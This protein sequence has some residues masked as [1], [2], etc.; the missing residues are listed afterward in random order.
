MADQ[1]Y[2]PEALS[3]IAKLIGV[4]ASL[5]TSIYFIWVKRPPEIISKNK[6][7]SQTVRIIIIVISTFFVFSWY[8]LGSSAWIE[9]LF[10]M[11]L[12][13]L[14]VG[15]AV[16]FL[17]VE[18]NSRCEA[19]HTTVGSTVFLLFFFIYTLTISFGLTTAGEFLAIILTNPLNY[20]LGSAIFAPITY[21]AK[22]EVSGIKKVS[23]ER[24]LP[25]QYTS[26]SVNVGCGGQQVIAVSYEVPSGAKLVGSPTASLV[27]MSNIQ[28]HSIGPV[29][30]IGD[31]VLVTGSIQGLPYQELPLGIRNCPGGGH[32]QLVLSG[33][34]NVPDSSSASREPVKITITNTVRRGA[35]EVSVPL[36]SIAEMNIQDIKTIFSRTNRPESPHVDLVVTQQEP[37]AE[38][39]GFMVR[40]DS[41]VRQ[42]ILSVH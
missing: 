28:S 17:T 4:I 5:G 27:N 16:F 21:I 18:L 19:G 1:T 6:F 39:A 9:I 3:A 36:P 25:F 2:N 42:L 13:F 37:L 35:A 32:A 14:V 22:V 40:Y 26:G 7:F 34:I 12:L 23:D 11:S 38:T 33:R 10:W 20:D 30:I 8:I 41:Q 15:L 31:S 29:R 24:I